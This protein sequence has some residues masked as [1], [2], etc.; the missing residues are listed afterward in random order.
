MMLIFLGPPGSGKGTQAK[1]LMETRNWPQLSTGDLLREE[2]QQGSELGKKAKAFMDRGELVPDDVMIGMIAQRI[3]SNAYQ[4]GCVFD[5][6]PRTLPQAEALDEALSKRER[7][8]DHVI[9]FEIS[10]SVLVPRL[11]GRRTCQSCGEVYHL[12]SKPPKTPETCDRCGKK[13]LK[14]RSDDREEVVGNR[15]TVYRKQ[16]A[17]LVTYYEEQGKLKKINADQDFDEV[18]KSLKEALLS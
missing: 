18:T 4:K 15:L 14:Q 2:I 11:T 5:G 1:R 7:S 17:P 8:I 10:D 9:L 12:L 13:A 3:D 16:T 6:F